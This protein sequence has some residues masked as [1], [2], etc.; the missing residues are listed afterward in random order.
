MQL[1]LRVEQWRLVALALAEAGRG[2]PIHSETG[3]SGA[4]RLGII[5]G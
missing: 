1:G 4:K 3:H 5:N 2:A